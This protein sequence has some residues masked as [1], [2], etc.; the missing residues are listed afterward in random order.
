MDEL[1]CG[2]NLHGVLIDENTLEVKCRSKACGAKR[3][4]VVLHRFDL[5]TGH[6]ISTNIYR[7]PTTNGEVRNGARGKPVALRHS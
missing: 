5:T 6:L 2:H 4:V 3:G 7:D 1:R